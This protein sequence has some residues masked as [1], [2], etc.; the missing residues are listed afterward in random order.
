[1]GNIIR[2]GS[3]EVVDISVRDFSGARIQ[4]FKSNSE[5]VNTNT[6]IIKILIEKYGV[7]ID[8][9]RLLNRKVEDTFLD[10]DSE[11]LKF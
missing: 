5:D 6:N 7:K 1:M 2:G 3:G 8:L 4:S 10:P 11:F 9:E